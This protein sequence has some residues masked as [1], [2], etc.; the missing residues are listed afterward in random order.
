MKI[1]PILS[2]ISEY[3][4]ALMFLTI[5]V[6]YLSGIGFCKTYVRNIV[7]GVIFLVISVGLEYKM[8]RINYAE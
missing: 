3:V 8:E 7:L 6:L 5:M 2:M 4:S 1:L